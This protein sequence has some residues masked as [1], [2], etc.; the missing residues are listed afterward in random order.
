M[1]HPDK[2]EAARSPSELLDELR[3]RLLRLDQNHP[4]RPREPEQAAPTDQQPEEPAEQPP[5]RPDRPSQTDELEQADEPEQ[6][7]EAH[8]FDQSSA[9]E[10]GAGS[11]GADPLTLPGL[12]RSSDAYRPWFMGSEA[13][14]PWFADE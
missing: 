12:S 4:S 5:E 7:D 3:L 13:G 9:G 10:H 14:V 11:S 2:A 1:D 6:P 8:G